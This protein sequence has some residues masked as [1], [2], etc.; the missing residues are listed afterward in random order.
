VAATLDDALEIDTPSFEHHRIELIRHYE[1]LPRMRLDR[2]KVLEIVINLVE[3][4]RDSL[5]ELPLGVERRL[6]V[7]TSRRGDRLQIEVSDNGVGIASENLTRIFS[8]GFTTKRCGHG[9]GL[10]ASA[11]AAA[12]MGGSL[13]AC[14]EGLGH[15]ATFVLELP[16]DPAEVFV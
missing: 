15:G 5:A 13:S 12:E 10:H 4:A 6:T 9:F 14:S 8:H 2:H 11:N 7:Q 16:F 3:N 1:D